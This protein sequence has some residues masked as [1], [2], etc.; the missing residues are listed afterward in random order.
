MKNWQVLTIAAA[1]VVVGVGAGYFFSVSNPA[2]VA[3]N[4]EKSEQISSVA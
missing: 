4:D 1:A 2:H 3:K